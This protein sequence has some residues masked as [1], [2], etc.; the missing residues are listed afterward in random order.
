MANHS[1]WDDIKSRRP[2]PANGEREANDQPF[3]I[4]ELIYAL[5]KGGSL[6][7]LEL[8]DRMGTTQS[9]ISRLEE[10]GSSGTRP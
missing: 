10:G 1:R 8:A 2:G 9:V 3:A 7:Q 4:G 6:S 5:R